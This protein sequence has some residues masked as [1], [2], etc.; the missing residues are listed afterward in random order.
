MA[1]YRSKLGPVGGAGEGGTR[2]GGV[3]V[4]LDPLSAFALMGGGGAEADTSA[5]ASNS[6]G[7]EHGLAP[8]GGATRPGKEK[9]VAPVAARPEAADNTLDLGSWHMTDLA[10]AAPPS[11]VCFVC[12]R[13]MCARCL[14]CVLCALFSVW[15]SAKFKDCTQIYTRYMV[16][17]LC[18]YSSS[19]L[20]DSLLVDRCTCTPSASTV[21]AITCAW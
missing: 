19:L 13:C 21:V 9:S 20:V 10:P 15:V 3:V 16:H 2:D 5:P 18:S 6:R 11:Q 12:A 4:D 8:G 7:A 17:D 1:L 14:L